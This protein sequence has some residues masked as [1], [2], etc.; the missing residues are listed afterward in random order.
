MER[1]I[2]ITRIFDAP[3]ELVYQAW[4]QPEHMLQWWGPKVFTNHS[5]EL[6]V[7]PGGPWQIV[8][9]APD[10]TDYGCKGIYTEVVE[11]ERLVFTNDAVDSAGQALL[12]GFTT[13]LFEDWNGKTKLTVKTRAVGLVPYAP[14]M[15]AGMEQGWSQ[16]L[17]KLG[18]IMP[19]LRSL[20]LR[21]AF[22][23]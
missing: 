2:E 19:S 1:E 5:C 10:G 11:P 9:R 7:R 4:I 23:A 12:K 14:Q 18:D 16:S 21:S 22:S 20:R 15:L 6:D 17:E 13:I 3:R 8:M